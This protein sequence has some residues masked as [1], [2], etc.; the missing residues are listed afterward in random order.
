MPYTLLFI[1]KYLMSDIIKLLP[2]SVANQIAA[3]EVI[4][5]PASI[6]KELVENSI[7]AGAS[8]IQVIV[9]NAG[10][11]LVQIIDDG[12]GM[13]ETDARMSFERHATSKIQTAEDIFHITTKG[14]RGEALASIAAVA[15]VEMKTKTAD[16][17]IGTKIIIEASEVKSQ[18][19]CQTSKGCSIAVKNLF[20]NIPVRRNFLKSD[21]VEFGQIISEFERVALAHPELSFV[22]V[23]ND[24]EHFHLEKGNF[25]QR[26][27]GL[28]GQNY[29][30]KLV[31]IEEHTDLVQI[32]GFITKP[33]FSRKKKSDQ[34]FLVN[35]R[36]VKSSYFNHAINN[37]Y[38]ELI[39]SENSVAYFLNLDI[40]PTSIDI[41]IHP[42][43]TE[44]KFEN[45]QAI[46]AI[47]RSAV[48]Q[49]LGKF[50]LAPTLDFEQETSFEIPFGSEPKEIKIPTIKVNENYNP[51]ENEK[52]KNESFSTPKTS[53]QS[54]TKPNKNFSNWESLYQFEETPK[55]QEQLFVQQDNEKNER[56]VAGE[57]KYDCI[58]LGDLI[59]TTFKAALMVIDIKKAWERITY[60]E[61]I[62]NIENHIHHSQQLLFPIK[63]ELTHKEAVIL[64][65]MLEV[66]PKFG[67]DI[68]DFGQ[69]TFVINGASPLMNDQN[70]ESFIKDLIE[71]FNF[72]PS[73]F[74]NN[75]LEK[76][77][78]NT[79]R[80]VSNFKSKKL[81]KDEASHLID[82]LFSTSVPFTAPSG[83]SIIVNIPIEELLM[84]F[85][86]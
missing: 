44:I 62:E 47:I 10:K 28:F 58:I 69:N 60:D 5:R 49:A 23:H 1:E 66:L 30:E 48:K 36:F 51:F 85:N 86:R 8:K 34:Y 35:N 19:P 22:L 83:K 40:P 24:I 50:Q 31:P 27:L 2:D 32:T 21:A 68:S 11:Q 18:E 78:L 74:R 80:F 14:F 75:L 46:Y 12:R 77:A 9:K 43:K 82:K 53:F 37:A 33:E 64:N 84:K 65:E 67:I 6:I 29:N 4:Q 26:I 57:K 16:N 41:N 54:F 70:I 55:K 61:I 13:S 3:G 42:T 56:I 25:R 38:D 20:Y 81:N 72:H 15:Q 59:F 17:E 71:Q 63:I 7:D 73:D 79:A 76:I 39:P 52:H 45:E